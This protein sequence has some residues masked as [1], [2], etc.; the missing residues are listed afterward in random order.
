[1]PCCTIYLT[2]PHAIPFLTLNP[3]SGDFPILLCVC[4]S[5]TAYLRR[6]PPHL[7]PASPSSPSRLSLLVSA[8]FYLFLSP[9]FC[10][11]FCFLTLTASLERSDLAPPL[12]GSIPHSLLLASL[13]PSPLTAHTRSLSPLRALLYLVLCVSPAWLS[14]VLFTLCFR[15]RGHCPRDVRAP[16]PLPCR[17][18]S[19]HEGLRGRWMPAHTAARFCALHTAAAGIRVSASLWSTQQLLLS[20]SRHPNTTPTRLRCALGSPPRAAPRGKV[21]LRRSRHHT[22]RVQ[23]SA[24]CFPRHR[25]PCRRLLS[26][27]TLV[28]GGGGSRGHGGVVSN[29]YQSRRSRNRWRHAPRRRGRVLG[30]SR[31]A[32]RA[33]TCRWISP[34][35]SRAGAV[36]AAAECPTP[37]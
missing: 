30:C 37:T 32:G 19:A 3:L 28:G 10:Y 7:C 11:L 27:A 36:L 14:T 2:H 25:R 26:T 8:S 24:R 29:H 6:L 34:G 17:T 9:L 22:T 33:Q 20:L 15:P 18:S 4:H 35:S 16:S 12:S 31:C 5:T 13:F 21:S 23:R 1:M